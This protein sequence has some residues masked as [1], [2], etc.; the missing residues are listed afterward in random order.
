MDIETKKKIIDLYLEGM[1]PYKIRLNLNGNIDEINEVISTYKKEQ[2]MN[3][4]IKG[5]PYALI[6]NLYMQE[7]TVPEILQEYP[8]LTF[9]E[10]KGVINGYFHML[11]VKKPYG[12]QF[13]KKLIMEDLK[14]KSVEEV[15]IE[16]DIPER[17]IKD[18]VGIPLTEEERLEKQMKEMESDLN[19]MRVSKFESKYKAKGLNIKYD[20]AKK[21]VR[22]YKQKVRNNGNK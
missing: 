21:L 20:T 8:E 22:E 9:G 6:H 13:P 10:V 7:K 17:V 19:S 5:I 14:T 18:R 3:Q 15:S 2:Y 1:R 4:E 16:Y 11:G 12:I